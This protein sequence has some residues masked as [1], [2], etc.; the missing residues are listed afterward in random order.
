MKPGQFSD[1]A[2]DC[3]HAYDAWQHYDAWKALGRPTDPE[4]AIN[5]VRKAW[6]DNYDDDGQSWIEANGP[7][8]IHDSQGRVNPADEFQAWK[9]AWQARAIEYTRHYMIEWYEQYCE[10]RAQ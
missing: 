3:S 4:A 9:A 10:D 8:V 7:D 2:W 1:G 5:V 6:A